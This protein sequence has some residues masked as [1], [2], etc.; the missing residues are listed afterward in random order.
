MYGK[1]FHLSVTN[2]RRPPFHTVT[3]CAQGQHIQYSLRV[4]LFAG[5]AAEARLVEGVHSITPCDGSCRGYPT[6]LQLLI[7]QEES[8]L[9]EPR[10]TPRKVAWSNFEDEVRKQIGHYVVSPSVREYLH[11]LYDDGD[12]DEAYLC[13]G[14]Y[15]AR[16]VCMEFGMGDSYTVVGPCD[17]TCRPCRVRLPSSV[18]RRIHEHG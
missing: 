6:D 16:R 7:E 9:E 11:T 17:R 12:S 5:H 14:Q 15:H 10:R 8:M 3:V 18:A 13:S 2:T 4:G 1:A